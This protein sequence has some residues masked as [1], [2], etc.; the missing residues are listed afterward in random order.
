VCERSNEGKE[1]DW[2]NEVEEHII[3]GSLMDQ[4]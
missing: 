2:E 3:I 4:G 1:I